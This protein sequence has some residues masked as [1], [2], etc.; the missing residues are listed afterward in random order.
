MAVSWQTLSAAMKLWAIGTPAD[1]TE[2]EAEKIVKAATQEE[3]DTAEANDIEDVRLQN[4]LRALLWPQPKP[5]ETVDV[6]KL[7]EAFKR[8]PPD[9]QAEFDEVVAQL[10]EL[11]GKKFDFRDYFQS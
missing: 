2:D 3:L 5:G 9:A 1:M 4:R 6:P 11:H 10:S 7:Y 8:A